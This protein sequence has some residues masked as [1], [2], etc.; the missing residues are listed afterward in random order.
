MCSQVF[1]DFAKKLHHM[2]LSGG[3][4]VASPQLLANHMPHCH[5]PLNT[6]TK[7]QEMHTMGE[8]WGRR[9]RG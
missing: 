4:D 5:S 3:G 8:D 9:G 6:H 7:L 1:E 2:E